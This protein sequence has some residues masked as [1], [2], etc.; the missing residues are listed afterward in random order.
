M[1]MGV[2]STVDSR[3]LR[4]DGDFLQLVALVHPFGG[5]LLLSKSCAGEP[6]TQ[7]NAEMNP[8]AR[9]DTCPLINCSLL[10]DITPRLQ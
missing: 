8:I 9:I 4:G 3:F 7:S 10:R 2:V 1:L 5:S 6:Q